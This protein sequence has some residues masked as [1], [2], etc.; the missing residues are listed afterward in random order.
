M[1]S[2]DNNLIFEQYKQVNEDVGLGPML[3]KSINV[4]GPGDQSTGAKVVFSLVKPKHSDA[5]TEEETVYIQSG[6]IDDSCGSDCGC[7][8]C[9][10]GQDDYDGEIDM[11]R[12]ELLKAAEYATKLFNHLEN[13]ESL[14]GWTASKITKA[15][16][17]LS[18]VYHALEYDALDADVEDEE[19]EDI[20]IDDY[21]AAKTARDTG[22]AGA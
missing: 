19:D 5:K 22:F 14:E 17:Y 2:I 1:A 7:N 13:I 3:G 4:P 18:S 9:N 10:D 12:A 11:A 21:D 8:S 6:D 15:S 20:E 16:D